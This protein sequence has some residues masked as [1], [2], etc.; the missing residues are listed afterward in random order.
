MRTLFIAA[1]LIWSSFCW[2]AE[3]DTDFW[4]QRWKNESAWVKDLP[5]EDQSVVIHLLLKRLTERVSDNLMPRAKSAGEKRVVMKVFFDG[6]ALLPELATH[7]PELKKSLEFYGDISQRFA[8][9]QIKP[10]QT[11]EEMEKNDRQLDLALAAVPSRYFNTVPIQYKHLLER[12]SAA[13]VV[14]ALKVNGWQYGEE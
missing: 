12:T 14:T 6:I 5:R 2:S 9:K 8:N 3:V 13:I 10:S 7:S 1:I 11:G 4:V